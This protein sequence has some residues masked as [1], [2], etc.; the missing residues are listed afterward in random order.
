MDK[1]VKTCGAALRGDPREEIAHKA[2]DLKADV[3]V[4]ESRGMEAMKRVFN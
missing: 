2:E 3:L 1:G 4:I